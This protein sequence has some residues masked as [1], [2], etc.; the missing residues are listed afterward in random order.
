MSDVA[1]YVLAGAMMTVG[2]GIPLGLWVVA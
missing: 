2:A 1:K